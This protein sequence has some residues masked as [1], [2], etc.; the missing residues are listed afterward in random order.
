VTATRLPAAERRRALVETALEAFS[1]GSYRGVGTAEIARRA[2]VTEPVLYRHFASKRELYLACLDEA[3]RRLREQWDAIREDEEPTDRL[4]K[5]AQCAFRELRPTKAL[6]ANLWI[7]ALTEASDD[8]EIRAYLR[9]HMRE[10]H[11]YVA[12]VI[13]D[14]QKAGV[15]LPDRDAVAEAWI[16]V[17]LVL[18]GSVG[19]RLGGLVQGDLQRIVAARREWMT[20][21]RE[22]GVVP[23]LEF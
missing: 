22:A 7:Q 19:R 4:P 5:L 8:P 23:P 3:W 2:G 13:R 11:D 21:L 18:L 1:A 10:V 16:L 20:G 6:L 9:R 15:V 17:S 12:A 14:L